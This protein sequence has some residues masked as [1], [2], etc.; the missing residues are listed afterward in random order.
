MTRRRSGRAL[1]IAAAGF[2]FLDGV[3]LILAGVWVG[4]TG[5]IVWGGLFVLGGVGVIRLWRRY[6]VQL[7]ELSAAREAL[8][9]EARRLSD[10]VKNARH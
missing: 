9:A 7:D 6:L 2:L 1:T 8:K 10:A 3:L 5:L 4:R